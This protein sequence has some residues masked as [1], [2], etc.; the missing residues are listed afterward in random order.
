MPLDVEVM[1]NTRED[2]RGFQIS[3]SWEIEELGLQLFRLNFWQVELK[4]LVFKKRHILNEIGC[5]WRH[6]ILVGRHLIEV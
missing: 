3:Q 6:Q 2:I 5:L 1:I 4:V